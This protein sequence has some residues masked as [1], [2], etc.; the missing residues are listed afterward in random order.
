MTASRPVH[1]SAPLGQLRVWH[2]APLVL[3]VAIAIANIQDH[4]PPTPGLV[5]L[6]ASGFVLY[7]LLGWAGWRFA[8][9]FEAGSDRPSCWSSTSPRWRC[10]SWWRRSCTSPW[11]S[12]P[13]PGDPDSNGM[14]RGAVMIDLPSTRWFESPLFHTASVHISFPDPSNAPIAGRRRP[15]AATR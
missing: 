10:S 8:H 3:F 6:A 15:P 7:G 5:A 12:T 13:P 11:R 4:R 9:R 1:Q 2:L 14:S